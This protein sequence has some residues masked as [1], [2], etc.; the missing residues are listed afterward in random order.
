MNQ[1]MWRVTEDFLTC[2]NLPMLQLAPLSS[3]F[4]FNTNLSIFPSLNNPLNLSLNF[5]LIQY[6]PNNQLNFPPNVIHCE[7][8]SLHKQ[9]KLP[10]TR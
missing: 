8:Q 9:L 6:A 2:Y 1:E 4:Y 3:L 10:M 7:T 5:P